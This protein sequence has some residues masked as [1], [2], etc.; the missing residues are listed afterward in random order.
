MAEQQELI[1]DDV[2]QTIRDTFLKD[3]KDDVAI[4]VYTLAGINDKFNDFAVDLVRSLATLSDKIRASF[5]TV[6]DAQ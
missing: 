4:E 2:K 1:P 3:L 5:H 6:G